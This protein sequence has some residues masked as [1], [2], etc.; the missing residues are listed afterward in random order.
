VDSRIEMG[1]EEIVGVT[2]CEVKDVDGWSETCDNLW[3]FVDI[4]GG[5]SNRVFVWDS[6]MT[7]S[8]LLSV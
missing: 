8:S 5:R 3:N 4:D 7:S 1:V 6:L 2:D